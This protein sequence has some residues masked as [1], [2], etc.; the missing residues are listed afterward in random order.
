MDIIIVCHTELGFV[1]NKRVI[2]DKKASQGVK[3]GV[4]NL[5]KLA[6]K[7]GAKVCFVV[8]PEVVEFF[9]KDTG[10][11]I[12]LHI[13]PGWEEFERIG[14]KW[15]VG[16]VYLKEHCEQSTISTALQDHSYSEQFNMIKTGKEY[17]KNKLYRGGKK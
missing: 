1:S 17:I 4:A 12:G 5:V 8:C 10:Q 16:D 14:F 7:Y 6:K 2:F 15:Q 9:P 13:H 11:E 3:D